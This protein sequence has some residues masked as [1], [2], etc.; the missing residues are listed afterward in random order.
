[1]NIITRFPRRLRAAALIAAG[2]VLLTVSMTVPTAAKTTPKVENGGT[3]T[4]GIPNAPDALDPTTEDTFVG[5]IIFTNM[6][7]TWISE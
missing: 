2:A 1:M 6:C 7:Q 4:V 3:I 5:R